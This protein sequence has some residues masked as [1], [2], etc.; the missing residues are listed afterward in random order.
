MRCHP[1]FSSYRHSTKLS[2]FTLIELLVVIAIIAVLAALLMPAIG[3]MMERSHG[4][5]CAGNMR[6]VYLAMVAFAN[7]NQGK[8]VGGD[9]GFAIWSDGLVS[10]LNLDS[11]YGPRGS[12]PTS[13]FACPS[14]KAVCGG[15]ERSDFATNYFVNGEVIP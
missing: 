5:K 6:Q 9:P 7:D 4:A 3:R 10:Y 1:R 8:I 13:A 15:G 14:S 2:A 12:R 11:N